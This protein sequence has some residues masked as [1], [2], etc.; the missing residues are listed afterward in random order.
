MNA[1]RGTY[2]VVAIGALL[3]GAAAAWWR[4]QPAPVADS[5]AATL[6][7]QRFADASG[8]QRVLSDWRGKVLVVNFWATWCAPCVEEMPDLQSVRDEYSARGVEVL[9]VGIDNAGNVV[10]FRD[11]LAIRFPLFVAGAG[12]SELAKALGNQAG[13]LPYTVLVSRDGRI[14]QRKIG[15]IKPPELRLWLQAQ[16]L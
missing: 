12:G 10:E 4:I 1:R 16:G 6:F 9:G 8:T 13:V 3:G 5:A 7:A 2:A 11:R 14:V 15:R